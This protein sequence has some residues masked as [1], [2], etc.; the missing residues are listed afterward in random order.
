MVGL[1]E[2]WVLRER[3]V[4]RMCTTVLHGGVCHRPPI[5]H[6]SGPCYVAREECTCTFCGCA[7]VGK[8][9]LLTCEWACSIFH[10][11]GLISVGPYVISCQMFVKSE[12]PLDSALVCDSDPKKFGW[13]FFRKL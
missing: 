8:W 7:G 10:S 11:I 2:G 1:S 6:K 13:H 9:H 3:S 12:F 4:G 5:P